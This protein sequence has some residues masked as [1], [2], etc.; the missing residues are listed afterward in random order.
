MILVTCTQRFP[1]LEPLVDRILMR[2]TEGTTYKLAA[3]RRA[4]VHWNLVG[5]LDDVD[6]GV[7]VGKINTGMYA[8]RV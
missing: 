5:A 6:D 7:Y 4:L 2:A 3:V 1:L 8:L